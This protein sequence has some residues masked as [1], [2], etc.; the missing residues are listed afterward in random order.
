MARAAEEP[1]STHSSGVERFL[2]LWALKIAI[3]QTTV[4]ALSKLVRR[5]WDSGSK[6]SNME[7]R[8]GRARRGLSRYP[9]YPKARTPH[10]GYGSTG[11]EPTSC[12]IIGPIRDGA[13]LL[14][15]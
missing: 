4:K 10:R 5:A 6:Q 2:N 8:H 9:R 11:E 3:C 7:E 1:V 14:L 15:R 13:R 12:G